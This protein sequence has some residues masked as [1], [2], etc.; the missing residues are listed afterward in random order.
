MGTH[1]VTYVY[2]DEDMIITAFYKHFDGYPSNY[3]LDL[4]IFLNKIHIVNGINNNRKLFETANGMDCLAAQL[5]VKFKQEVGDIYMINPHVIDTPHDYVYHVY[6]DTVAVTD[7]SNTLFVG[8]WND[9]FDFCNT[10]DA[11]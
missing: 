4:A 8:T 5:I 1:A 11:L 9:F 2:D 6:R 10:Y 7:S 3:G